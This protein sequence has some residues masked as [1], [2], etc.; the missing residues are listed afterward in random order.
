M[1]KDDTAFFTASVEGARSSSTERIAAV[2]LSDTSLRSTFLIFLKGYVSGR[3]KQMSTNGVDG[4][5]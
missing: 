4:D 1:T 5:T 3:I 2:V